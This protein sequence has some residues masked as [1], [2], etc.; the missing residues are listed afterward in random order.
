[1]WESEQKKP[2]YPLWLGRKEVS[3]AKR[4]PDRL[5]N[6]RTQRGVHYETKKGKGGGWKEGMSLPI[7]RKEEHAGLY[8]VMHGRP[9]CTVGRGKE[10]ALFYRKKDK[11]DGERD[12]FK[13]VVIPEPRVRRPDIGGVP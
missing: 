7:G 10:G 12:F 1:V 4:E 11:T 5:P 9:G 2:I 3:G 6:F 8:T 13:D